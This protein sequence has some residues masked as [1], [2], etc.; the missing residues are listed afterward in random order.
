[1]NIN[2]DSDKDARFETFD[3]L[4]K[5]L[6]V[7]Y[8]STSSLP[9]S[10][11]LNQ[12]E[13]KKYVH[14]SFEDPLV[15]K[16]AIN[17]VIDGLKKFTV[18]TPHPNYF[19]LFNPRANFAGILADTITATF[20]PQLAAWSH[21][22]FAAEVESNLIVEFGKKFGYN[23]SAI[24]GV[25]TTGGAEANLTAILCALNK[26]FPDYA[27]DGLQSLD[28]KP[29]IYVS[30]ESHHSLVKAA[31]ITGLGLKAVK[32]IPVNEYLQIDIS[33]LEQQIKDDIKNNLLPIMIV[34]TMGTTGAGAIDAINEIA[35][36]ASSYNI[37]LHADAAY[38]G[39]LVL[40]DQYKTL[41]GNIH[42]ADSI[43]F[44]AHKSMSV[45]M[46]TSMFIT[47]HTHILNKTFRVTTDYMPKE[48]NDLQVTDPFTHSIQWSRR[49]T[50]L[51]IYLSLLIFGWDG[52]QQVIEQQI[53]MGNI[54]RDKLLNSGWFIYNKTHLPIVCFGNKNFESDA[55]A[56]LQVSKKIIESGKAWL[57]VYKIN[58]VNTLRACITNYASNENNIE[59]LVG[60][61][62]EIAE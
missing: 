29:L 3:Y 48:A 60:L 49:F 51:K 54:L 53:K 45:P 21:A 28:K 27:K 15:Y 37:W 31:S 22:P 38:G 40:S 32:E 57:S 44:D 14:H 19:G 10:P 7:Y 18:H 52:Y 42:L 11:K 33:L 8:A 59:E 9:V 58:G 1:M 46:N 55:N 39:A 2:F 50:G 12:E 17:H 23:P 13:I 62:N 20:N 6:E 24:D 5:Q 26:A 43:T 34:A 4:N 36:I 16:D 25:F 56:A 61:L 41:L 30:A 47:K 35:A